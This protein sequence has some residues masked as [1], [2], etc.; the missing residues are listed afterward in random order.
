MG[1]PIRALLLPA[2]AMMAAGCGDVER[3]AADRFARTGEMVALSGGDAGA[4]AACFTCHGLDG[5]GDGTAVPRLAGIDPGYLHRQMEAYAANLRLH[6]QMQT[7]ARALPAEQRA[8]VSFYY[9][10]M[11]F[12]A[13]P[14][15]P[16]PIPPLWLRGD[17]ARGIEACATCHG[18][19][20][21]GVGAAN[22]PLAGQPAAYLDAQI[23]AWRA[24]D[25]RTDPESTML[26]IARALSPRESQ[27]LA[28]HARTL[29]G[30]LPRPES[31]EASPAG[32][33][34][35][36]RNDVSARRPHEAEP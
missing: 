10:A 25:R 19:Q 33:R 35:D 13:R 11:P 14:A 17:P 34:A 12:T 23:Q 15:P 9:G 8:A 6:P 36:P 4:S 32:R 30:G 26:A 29:A 22:P 3:R 18:L 27:D 7:V 20:G 31:P 28:A 21:E 24:S 2:A 1:F 16:R 5:R